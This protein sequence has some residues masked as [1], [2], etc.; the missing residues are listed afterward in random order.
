MLHIEK[1]EVSGIHLSF[2]MHKS[3]LNINGFSTLL[4]KGEVKRFGKLKPDE[5]MPNQVKVRPP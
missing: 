2:D 4:A 5:P 3:K 1:L